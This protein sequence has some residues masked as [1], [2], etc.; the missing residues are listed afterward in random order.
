MGSLIIQFALIVW[1]TLE[2]NS[3]LMLSLASFFSVIPNLLLTPIAGVFSDRYDRKKVILVADSLQ[4]SLT[5]V[6]IGFFQVNFINPIILFG[7]MSLRSACQ[8]FHSPTALA[9]TP[10]MVPKDKLSRMNGIDYLFTGLVNIIGSPFAGFLLTFFQ[11]EYILWADVI[12]FFMAL[13]P[14]ILIKIPKV[15]GITQQSEKNSF[16]KEFKTGIKVM[17]SIPGL[18]LIMLIAMLANFLLQPLF[19]LMPF[20]ILNKHG[21]RFS[22]NIKVY[23]Y[24]LMGMIIPLTSLFGSLVPTIKKEWK[25]KV[26]VLIT[27]LIVTNIGY[28]FYALAPNASFIIISLGAIAIGFVNPIINSLAMT[29]FQT[30]T[31]KDKIGRVMS[32]ILTLSMVISPLGAILSGPLSLI[33]GLSGLYFICA[34]LGILLAVGSY[35]FT[36]LKQVDFDREY[37]FSI[38]EEIPQEDS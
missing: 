17:K 30:I 2:T 27:G 34:I 28:L 22:A 18:L 5:V 36:G 24:G 19:V 10:S 4:A 23:I 12:T 8:S 15:N 35:F 7:F 31:P 29:V 33:F 9:I 1:I 26:K 20:Y 3:L 38:L 6:L 37:E 11:L 32:I 25:N 13:I 16:I 21:A 14:L